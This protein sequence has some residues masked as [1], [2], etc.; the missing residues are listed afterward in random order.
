LKRGRPEPVFDPLELLVT[1][2][3]GSQGKSLEM[4]SGLNLETRPQQELRKR[5]GKK[6]DIKRKAQE[7]SRG[8]CVH[9]N[10]TLTIKQEE[11]SRKSPKKE[12]E[13]HPLGRV[14][15][16]LRTGWKERSQVRET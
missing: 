16:L 13:S 1:G 14:L 9:C 12:H 4:W 11:P 15:N 8:G 3:R 2:R 10:I 5:V 7:T 6:S